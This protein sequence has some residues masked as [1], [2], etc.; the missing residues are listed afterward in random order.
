MENNEIFDIFTI[1]SLLI[2]PFIVKDHIDYDSPIYKR[3]DGSYI[4]HFV[5]E[6][7]GKYKYYAS[8]TD[9]IIYPFLYNFDQQNPYKASY[10]PNDPMDGIEDVDSAKK[11]KRQELTYQRDKTMNDGFVYNAHTFPLNPD[12]QLVLT[13]EYLASQR[14]NAPIYKWKD[15]HGNYITIGNRQQFQAFCE[16]AMIYGKV[17]YMKEQKLQFLLDMAQTLDAVKAINWNVAT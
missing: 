9:D 7:I 5:I 14:I 15:I 13:Q 11:L 12:V 16:H 3:H 8:Y 2:T 1:G 10:D 6:S 17:I 4:C